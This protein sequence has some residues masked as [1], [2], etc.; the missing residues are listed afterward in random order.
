MR[1]M[2]RRLFIGIAIMIIIVGAAP[3]LYASYETSLMAYWSFDDGT[4]NDSSGNNLNPITTDAFGNYPPTS[5][6][7]GKIEKSMDFNGT[8]NYLSYGN[9]W[10]VHNGSFT[11]AAWVKSD[12]LRL[13]TIMG[14][15]VWGGNEYGFWQNA[16]GT[17]TYING[18][19]Q[20]WSEITSDYAAS[21]GEWVH[22]MA[23]RDDSL[24]AQNN[25]IYINGQ[26]QSATGSC[27][28]HPDASWDG[29]VTDT[30]LLGRR[31]Y[32]YGSGHYF[33]GHL[34]DVAVWSDALDANEVKAIYDL[35]MAGMS[36]TGFE[37][38]TT[39]IVALGLGYNTADILKLADLYA[40]GF[41]SIILSGGSTW[42]IIEP[43]DPILTDDPTLG[44][45]G[46]PHHNVGDAW[47]EVKNS[48]TYHYIAMGPPGGGSEEPPE[49]GDEEPPD[50]GGEEP[51][52]DGGGGGDGGGVPEP[53]TMV[54]LGL[55]VIAAGLR[56][57]RKSRKS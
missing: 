34:D 33:D 17:F 50:D 1:T 48:T 11:L 35:G 46:E 45:G 55:A 13:Q 5:S 3:P 39:G 37:N 40:A 27:N 7:Y 38:L 51:P 6:T 57:L 43:G 47:T 22:V 30:F 12:Q 9:T 53:A 23:I 36:L 21:V 4:G 56:R 14:K 44:G 10:D 41:G 16:D 52:D 49:G 24:G 29:N 2:T 19:Y 26:L 18:N 15:V 31:T 54:G 42:Y 20:N 25:I 8:D 28:Y 32:K